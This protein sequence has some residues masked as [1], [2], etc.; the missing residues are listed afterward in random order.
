MAAPPTMETVTHIATAADMEIRAA[1]I[2]DPLIG[3]SAWTSF[4]G[5]L[6][7]SSVELKVKNVAAGEIREMLDTI[8]DVETARVLP[9][10]IP[11]LL[12]LLRTGEP[13]MRNDTLEYAFR[14]VVLEILN[15][16]PTHDVV[17]PHAVPIFECLLYVIRHDN[18]DIGVT[19]CK[20]I[21][22][23]VKH[24]RCLNEEILAEFTA[25]FQESFGNMHGL[26]NEVLSENSIVLDEKVVLP[27]MRSFKVLAEMGLVMAMFSQVHRNLIVPAVQTT[28]PPAFEVLSLESPAQ[29]TAREDFEAMGGYW[30]GMSPTIRNVAAYAEF[31]NAQ[32][33]VIPLP[34]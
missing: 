24:Y 17:R 28:I 7:T 22:D 34:Y 6:L 33:K 5:H 15:R 19:C 3:Q 12:Q 2:A 9:F 18:E 32:I 30:A 4:T 13:A 21:I 25:I 23:L 31:V 26:V 16:L 10:M 27:S 20:T 8:R 29:K 1:R 14:R 11:T